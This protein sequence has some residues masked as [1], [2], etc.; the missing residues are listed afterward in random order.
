[1]L[2]IKMASHAQGRA[3]EG[4]DEYEAAQRIIRP[5]AAT[6]W[7][8]EKHIQRVCLGFS[9][10]TFVALNSTELMEKL[11][12]REKKILCPKS[13]WTLDLKVSTFTLS[14]SLDFT[15]LLELESHT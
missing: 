8:T 4:R 15:D 5:A 14:E 12:L 9:Q 6:V 13:N 1:M 7:Y 2:A 11:V 3:G 10:D